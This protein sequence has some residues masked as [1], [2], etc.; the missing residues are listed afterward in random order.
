MHKSRERRSRLR[1]NA[2]VLPEWCVRLT[3]SALRV[4]LFIRALAHKL[5]KPR[6]DLMWKTRGGVY[7]QGINHFARANRFELSKHIW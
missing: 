3:K 4:T 7:K 6:R 1:G 5:R 2:A